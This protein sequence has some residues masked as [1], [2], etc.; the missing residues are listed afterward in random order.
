MRSP[1][2]LWLPLVA[3]FRDDRLDEASPRRVVRHYAAQPIDGP[4]VAAATGEGLT[5]DGAE[6]ERLV[7]VTTAEAAAN[8]SNP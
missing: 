7:R 1:T 6:T 3:P 2:G 8:R 5:L 4:I